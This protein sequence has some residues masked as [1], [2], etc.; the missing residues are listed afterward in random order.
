VIK[1]ADK[2]YLIDNS[3]NKAHLIAKFQLDKI[4]SV[5]NKKIPNWIKQIEEIHQKIEAYVKNKTKRNKLF[6]LHTTKR[7]L[8]R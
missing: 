6:P 8:K 2:A 3:T 5:T 1:I 7:E 4:L